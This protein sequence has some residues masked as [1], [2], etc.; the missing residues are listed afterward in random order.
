MINNYDHVIERI[1]SQENICEG[2]TFLNDCLYL[3]AAV[4]FAEA[5]V[6]GVEDAEA[7]PSR[8]SFVE[9]IK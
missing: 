9:T 2:E 6:G 8:I 3:T 7:V 1:L 4:R 5:R